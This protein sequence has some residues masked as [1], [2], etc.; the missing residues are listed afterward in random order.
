MKASTVRGRLAAAV[1]S[2]ALVAGSLAAGPAQAATYEWKFQTTESAGSPLVKI[3]K[4]WA[5]RVNEMTDGRVKIEILPVGAV[6]PP[7]QTLTAVGSGILQGHITDPSYFSGKNPAFGMLG[8]LVGAWSDPM[9]F[10][11]Y[12]NYGGGEELYN[13]LVEPYGVHLIGASVAGLESLV[14]SRP[15][16]E[17]E[18][19]K[20]LKMRAPQGMVNNVFS[21]AGATPVNLPTSEVYTALE[22]GV[23]DAADYNTFANNQQLGLHEFAPYPIYPGFHSMPMGAVSINKDVWSEL[24]D[25][26]KTILETSVDYLAVDTAFRMHQLDLKAVAKARKNDDIEIIDLPKAER[27]K[28]RRIAQKEW[29]NWAEKNEMCQKV[30]DSVV[31]FLKQRD[32]M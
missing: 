24:P 31:A 1:A 30:Y 20:G 19:L 4:D 10:I 23:I 32:L 3:Q 9:Q 21:K 25:D 18:D 5:E 13:Q 8:N 11:E 28:F 7:S 6:V 12:M 26:L 15:I 27:A 22:K 17:I 14:S 16:R 2:A 29:A